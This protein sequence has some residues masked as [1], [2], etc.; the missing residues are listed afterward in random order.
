[1]TEK[2]ITGGGEENCQSYSSTVHLQGQVVRPILFTIV[3]SYLKTALELQVTELGISPIQIF[4][5]GDF[6]EQQKRD[7]SQ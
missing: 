3:I 5:P 7:G 4:L 6:E 1:M 2:I